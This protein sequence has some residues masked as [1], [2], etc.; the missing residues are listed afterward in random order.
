[1]SRRTLVVTAAAWLLLA[2]GGCGEGGP[3]LDALRAD[4]LA[5][6]RPPGAREVETSAD[7]E[8]DGGVLGK[9][10]E[11]RFEHLYAVTDSPANVFDDALG[12]AKAAGWTVERAD[13]GTVALLVKN[14]ATG[15]ASATITLLESPAGLPEGVS[16]P[17]LSIVL[18]HRR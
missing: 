4:P 13:S 12:A 16:P 10:R 15:R 7:P 9:P 1:M 8:S 2:V 11:A 6:Y 5:D 17:A 18:T 3:Q 14:L